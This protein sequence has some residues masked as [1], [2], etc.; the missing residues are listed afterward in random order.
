MPRRKCASYRWAPPLVRPLA[1]KL[2][3]SPNQG[4]SPEMNLPAVGGA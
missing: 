2:G 4:H 3:L 1:H